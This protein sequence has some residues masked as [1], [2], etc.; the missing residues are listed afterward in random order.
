MTFAAPT[1]TATLA[2]LDDTP[3]IVSR[4]FGRGR[5]IVS[6]ALDA[7]RY[8]DVTDRFDE[9]WTALTWEASLLAGA[10]LRLWTDRTIAIPG[11]QVAVHVEQ[12]SMADSAGSAESVAAS[13]RLECGGERQVL[14]LWPGARAGSF[15]AT[16]RGDTQGDCTIRVAVG[17]A[18]ASTPVT[19]RDDL[20]RLSRHDP[21]L[22]AI[23]A[24][25]E[26][27][28]V[29]AAREDE[30]VARVRAQL[31]SRRERTPD[32]PMRSPSWIVPFVL[33]L[34]VEWWLRR[35]NGLS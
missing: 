21:R 9:F 24:A 4:A 33:C 6:G 27:V 16:F 11:E 25:H 15:T 35:R 14:R 18:E 7:W 13:G 2:A 10:R 19:I 20:Q 34:G 5:I 22:E 8:R 26:A 3:V 28:F 23:A 17:D 32:W 1:G 12:Q 30:L 29:T 31:T